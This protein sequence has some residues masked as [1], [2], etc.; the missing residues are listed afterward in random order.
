MA[1]WFFFA[2]DNPA[3]SK[4]VSAQERALVEKLKAE[5]PA[6]IIDADGKAHGMGY[7]LRQPI[8]LVTAFAFFCTTILFF[9]LSWFPAYLV[10]AHGLDIKAMS[11][12]TMI[13]WIVGLLARRWRL[14]F[15]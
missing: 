14:D 8:I 5:E 12:T 11:I 10:Q 9:F 3:R 13:P 1:L 6:D 4:R 15:R 2:A 7:Y